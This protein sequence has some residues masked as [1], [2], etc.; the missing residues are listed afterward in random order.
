MSPRQPPE[1]S[2]THGVEGEPERSC[3]DA[4][5]P[6]GR[7]LLDC[8]FA[9]QDAV[10]AV[11]DEQLERA[12]VK[13]PACLAE[14]GTVLGYLDRMASCWWG[15][16]QGDH[17]IEYL[18]G[19]AVSQTMAALRLMRFGLYDEALLACRGVGEIANL[20]FLFSFEP[21]S[22]SEW[23][24]APEHLRRRRFSP[25]AVRTRLEASRGI[26]PIN[27][28]RYN[29]LSGL[30]AHV[31]PSTRPQ[32]HNLVGIP[33]VGIGFQLA[34]ALA[35]LNEIATALGLVT[36]GGSFLLG[37]NEDRRNE[38]HQACRALAMQIGSFD[39]AG[40]AAHNA[41]FGATPEGRALF[42]EVRLAF[43]RAGRVAPSADDH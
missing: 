13:A 22:F 29:L 42:E 23:V 3:S 15:C 35:C 31:N 38:I 2:P 12:G 25:V 24:A 32:A 10:E 8:L 20:L 26:I 19:R 34:G 4:A 27:E 7:A 37:F 43:A 41:A 9:N 21:T 36:I 17:L 14:I 40:A 30:A 28:D 39:L 1:M 18:C 5:L 33:G 11:S 16:R 6:V